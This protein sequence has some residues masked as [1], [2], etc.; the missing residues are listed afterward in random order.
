MVENKFTFGFGQDGWVLRLLY[1][2]A[3]RQEGSV[4]EVTASLIHVAPWSYPRSLQVLGA[5]EIGG[6]PWIPP[7]SLVLEQ[8][9]ALCDLLLCCSLAAR[10]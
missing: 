9:K 5:T 10:A 8:G 1:I 4:L 2:M 6:P 3:V 7:Y